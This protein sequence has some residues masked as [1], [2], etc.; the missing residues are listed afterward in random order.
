[1]GG[2]E[3]ISARDLV[4]QN[5]QKHKA[6]ARMHQ[7]TR[8]LAPLVPA[9]A[10]SADQQRRH[11]AELLAAARAARHGDA[12][13]VN[14][15]ILTRVIVAADPTLGGRGR[16]GMVWADQPDGTRRNLIRE[17][18]LI[19]WGWAIIEVLRHTGIRI[20]E[21]TEL[22]HRSFVAYTLP[23]TGETIPLLQITPS[24]TDKERLLV[25]S[26][27]LADV[28][29]AI[30]HRVRAGADQIPLITRYDHA[31]RTHSPMLPF[32]FQRRSGLTNS[33][34]TTSAAGGLV[35]RI[36]ARSG[37]THTDGT[38]AHLTP[39]DFRRIFA[40]EAVAAGLPVHIAAKVLGHDNLN[41]TQAYAA[42]YDHDVIEHHRAYIAR[43]SAQ[44][45]SVEYR[46][47]T[48]AEWD[49]FLS[50]FE[51]RK[52]ELG[53]CGRAYATPCIH[54]HACVRCPLLRPEPAQ[55]RRLTEIEQN[56]RDRIT[57]AHQRGWTGEIR[58]A[59]KSASPAP[60]KSS[61][62]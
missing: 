41:T 25:V 16:A 15:E 8:E 37:I 29:A 58:R 12:F 49:E 56:L 43:R 59:S 23:S 36:V 30:I 31:E 45:P 51:H 24:K 52:V 62:R 19:F 1:M 47:V 5:K 54:E 17:E 13:T 57:E 38:P 35:A 46:D 48:D 4:R 11:A 6:R 34:I 39:H 61:N 21:L 3:P 42:V 40:T 9:L 27:E 55:I 44:R 2:T 18:D 33:M 32:L 14:G 22:T 26:P 60:P 7:R 10:R 20:E 28:L 53:T 50:H